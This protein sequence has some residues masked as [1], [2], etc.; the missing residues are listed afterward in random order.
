MTQIII[1]PPVIRQEIKRVPLNDEALVALVTHERCTF[2]ISAAPPPH[3][4]LASLYR[5]EAKEGQK[6]KEAKTHLAPRPI[7]SAPSRYTRAER[8]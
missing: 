1:L 6:E 8:P 7:A 4:R 5:R 2:V 3:P